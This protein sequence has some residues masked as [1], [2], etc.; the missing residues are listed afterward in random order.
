MD[1]GCA[2]GPQISGTHKII[3]GPKFKIASLNVNGLRDGTFQGT[4]KRRK[5]FTWIKQREIDIIL[6]QETHSSE[7]DS[8]RWLNQWGGTGHFAH[9]ERNSRGVGILARPNSGITFSNVFADK[10]GRFL[11]LYAELN[12]VKITIGNV[13]APNRDDPNMLE[14]FCAKVDEYEDNAT[15][16]GGDFNF[17]FDVSKDRQSSAKIVSNNNRNRNVITNFMSEKNLIDIWRELNPTKNEYTFI[18]NNP[19]SKSRIDFFLI[20]QSLIYSHVKP[21]ARILDGYLTDHKLITLTVNISGVETGK[22]YWKFNNGLL[23]DDNFVS[24]IRERIPDIIRS[25]EQSASSCALLLE[26]LLCVLRGE[27]L[28]YAVTKRRG[29]FNELNEIEQKINK[30]QEDGTL[31]NEHD[32]LREK[33]DEIISEMTEK[34]MFWAKV[35]WRAFAEKGSKYFHNLTKRNYPRNIMREM[36][37]KEEKRNILTNKT[38]NMLEEGKRYFETLF[39]RQTANEF[40]TEFTENLPQLTLTNKNL[41][42]EDFTI[43][44]LTGAAFSIKNNTSPGP[45]GY[46]GEFYKFFW[47]ELKT[48]VFAT[49]KEIFNT[50]KMPSSLKQSVTVL[51]PKKNKDPRK[52][53]NL[54][55]ISLLNTFY[56]IVTKALAMRLAKVAPNIINADQTGFLKGRY[57]GENIR[58]ILDVISICQKRNIPGILLACD[59]EKAYDS[60]DWSYMKHTLKR[61]GFGDKFRRWVD[62]LYNSQC[63]TSCHACVQINGKLSRPYKIERGLRQGCPLSCLLFLVCFEPLLEKIR[64]DNNVKGL[65]INGVSIKVSSYADDLTIIMD[66]SEKS[67]LRCMNIFDDFELASG[68][69]LNKHKSQALWLGR[70]GHLREPICPNFKIQWPSTPINYLGVKITNDPSI[71]ISQV[72]YDEKLDKMKSKLV[73]WTGRGLTPYG[74]VHLLKTELMSQLVYIM[75]VLPAPHKTFMKQVEKLMFEFIWGGKKDRIK[76]M[77]LKSKYKDGGLKVPDIALQAQS[78]KISWIKRYLDENNCAK[79]KGLM[80]NVLSLNNEISLFHCN[81]NAEITKKIVKNAFWEEVC[82]AWENIKQTNTVQAEPQQDCV[83]WA[84]KHLNIERNIAVDRKKLMEKGI[85]RFSDICNMQT[86][87]VLTVNEISIKFKIHP[88]TSYVIRRAIPA[89]WENKINALQDSVEVALIEQI[90]ASSKPASWAYSKLIEK[91]SKSLIETCHLKW[92]MELCNGRRLRWSKV[93][94]I[95]HSAVEDVKLRWLNYRCIRRILPTNKLLFLYKIKETDLCSYCHQIETIG[96][97]LWHCPRV[98]T[99]WKSVGYLFQGRNVTYR[100]VLIGFEHK[101]TAACKRINTV[102]SLGKQFVWYNRESN[103]LRKK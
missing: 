56:K 33:R 76:R 36:Y 83:L 37:I 88:M 28:K 1:R 96:H 68:L 69:K 32:A 42:D 54:R 94:T 5:L 50:E 12:G 10:N 26:T 44:E 23:K 2:C 63:D 101:N 92:E 24:L 43:E 72:N 97:M 100:T 17:C 40:Q 51:I 71:D 35:R 13:Y 82:A 62:I 20:S 64:C 87:K 3:Q 98:Q 18:R 59:Q 38:D 65:T 11:I 90:Q 99:F 79:W 8:I 31:D 77:T 61:F 91:F 46:T 39:K 102:L 55:P 27:I 67:L 58:L 49:C 14:D 60:V 16:I 6:L 66:G 48:L 29:C 41:C 93:Y 34:G 57:I 85:V 30:T 22:G 52:I 95:L 15:V 45:S 86:K 84:N 78:L 19:V 4:S 103:S 21:K 47:P 7:S 80:K 73:P 74:R 70:N 81:S 25:N 75:T 53:G 89:S 9:G